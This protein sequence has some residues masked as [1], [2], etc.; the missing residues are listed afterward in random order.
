M[1]TVP[2]SAAPAPLHETFPGVWETPVP[3]VPDRS[4][5]SQQ[6]PVTTRMTDNSTWNY[7][8]WMTCG[9]IEQLGSVL[10]GKKNAIFPIILA[11]PS[12]SI[13]EGLNSGDLFTR[14]RAGFSAFGQAQ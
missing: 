3:F 4:L 7:C 1:S 2:W 10:S 9:I 13:A 5:R 12:R 8:A 11:A 14:C 6:I